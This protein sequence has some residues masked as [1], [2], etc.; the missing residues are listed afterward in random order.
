MPLDLCTAHTIGTRVERTGGLS[1]KEMV[2][3]PQPRTSPGS[4]LC[5]PCGCPWRG[6]QIHQSPQKVAPPVKLC[7]SV[8]FYC[9][10]WPETML[11]PLSTEQ[12]PHYLCRLLGG[13]LIIYLKY[14]LIIC[15]CECVTEFENSRRLHTGQSG[16]H[17]MQ[18][19]Y[20]AFHER[21]EELTSKLRVCTGCICYDI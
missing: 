10:Q 4:W 6:S 11:W 9:L 21:W 13:V 18:F 1:L 12:E 5:L 7:A 2:A 14:R 15:V 20:Y 17:W 19:H 16:F 3:G 8:I